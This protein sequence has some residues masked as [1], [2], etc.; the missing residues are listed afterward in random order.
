MYGQPNCS[1]TVV[2]D[3]VYK[4]SL[5]SR[6]E[7]G[8]DESGIHSLNTRH[9]VWSGSQAHIQWNKCLIHGSIWKELQREV[10]NHTAGGGLRK[11]EG[12]R[13]AGN[14]GREGWQG[15]GDSSQKRWFIIW[16]KQRPS[17]QGGLQLIKPETGDGISTRDILA[18][19]SFWFSLGLSRSRD[20]RAWKNCF[21]VGPFLVAKKNAILI[22]LFKLI[23]GFFSCY[24]EID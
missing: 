15:I 7:L 22:I 16:L 24:W 23:L 12:E 14:G 11:A 20:R 18:G 4:H 21:S 17:H 2:L 1:K 8:M 3:I 6:Y 19:L 5:N 13:G 10:P 9:S